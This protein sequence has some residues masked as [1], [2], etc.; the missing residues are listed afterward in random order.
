MNAEQYAEAFYLTA[1][2]QFTR[3]EFFGRSRKQPLAL[4]RQ[5]GM[6]LAAKNT[7]STLDDIGTAFGNRGYD[8]VIF[9]KKRVERHMM[10]GIRNRFGIKV[11]EN[12]IINNVQKTHI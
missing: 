7:D 3:E 10:E 5:I 4:Y 8:T 12:V 9:A 1:A 2:S 11:M 6:Y